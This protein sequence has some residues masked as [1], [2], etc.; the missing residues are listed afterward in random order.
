[1]TQIILYVILCVI[2]GLLGRWRLIGFIGFTLLGLAVHPLFALVV[3]ILTARRS[4]RGADGKVWRELKPGEK[5][6]FFPEAP[7]PAVKEG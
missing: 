1:M 2:V 7:P 3:L 4:P 5:R 6:P